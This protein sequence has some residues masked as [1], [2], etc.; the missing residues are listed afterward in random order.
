MLQKDNAKG[1]R[2]G[3]QRGR[4]QRYPHPSTVKHHFL[5]GGNQGKHN[6]T[7]ALTTTTHVLISKQN[8]PENR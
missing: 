6:Q 5:R 7:K 1:Q 2:K 3:K 8:A 4:M